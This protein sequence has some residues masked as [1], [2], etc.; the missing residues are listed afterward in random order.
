VSLKAHERDG[1]RAKTDDD[2]S[3]RHVM[4][5][6]MVTAPFGPRVGRLFCLPPPRR[7]FCPRPS[8]RPP[9]QPLLPLRLPALQP[10]Y[11]TS[12][13]FPTAMSPRRPPLEFWLRKQIL[14]LFP[15]DHSVT[16]FDVTPQVD[17]PSLL[18]HRPPGRE[19]KKKGASWY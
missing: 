18:K 5:I 17:S 12:K 4:I 3:V 15:R 8:L 10:W 9:A 19:R 16:T 7:L 11:S 6:T 1:Q 14:L 2:D 13:P